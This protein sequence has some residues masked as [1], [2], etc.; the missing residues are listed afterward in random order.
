MVAPP[1]ES[2]IRKLRTRIIYNGASPIMTDAEF[3]ALQ[4]RLESLDP[5]G[6][7][8]RA[9]GAPVRGAKA[10][11]LPHAMMSLDKVPRDQRVL[12]SVSNNYGTRMVSHVCTHDVHQG[13]YS[14]R[15]CMSKRAQGRYCYWREQVN[16][17]EMG[18][19]GL[20]R[21]GLFYQTA[22]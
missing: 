5:G 20:G 18:A 1:R 17:V 8:V 4:D 7:S 10:M 21:V 11:R 16:R 15:T 6:S 22:T 12:Y 13:S 19:S 14:L 3:D 9:V 2:Q